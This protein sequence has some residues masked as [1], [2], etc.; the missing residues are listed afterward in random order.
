MK[1]IILSM[2]LVCPPSAVWATLTTPEDFGIELQ[3]RVT[4]EVLVTI[5]SRPEGK[6]QYEYEIKSSSLSLQAIIN[7]AV[8]VNAPVSKANM[9]A[10]PTWLVGGC[11][12]ADGELSTADWLAGPN[13]PFIKPGASLRGFKLVVSSLPGIK[14]FYVQGFTT[15]DKAEG[16]FSEEEMAT[17]AKVQ[18]YFTTNSFS[19][20]TLGPDP[21]PE[22]IN[23]VGLIDRLISL[24][25]Q[26]VFLGWL[27]GD[28][29]IKK[30]DKKL[31][32]AKKALVENKPFKARKKL[33]QFIKALEQQRKEQQK[34][35]HEASEKGREERAE[36][37]K[38]DKRFINDNA[39]FLLK[40]NAEFIIS[41][42]PA[43]ER[44]EDKDD[45]E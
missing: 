14:P 19:G 13:D 10:A 9:T 34:R 42:L 30:L 35:Q 21:V 15:K 40:V 16:E 5:Q 4:A 45:D 33:E 12:S 37:S 39:F 36:H 29:F 43:K 11:C 32:Q 23:L 17:L 44:G 22:V 20:K 27:R 28:E 8:Q 25:H 2:L 3:N 6:L 38:D 7:F 24:K 1:K 41:K 18:D 26:S 31:D